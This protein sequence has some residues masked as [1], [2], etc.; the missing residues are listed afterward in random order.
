[1]QRCLVRGNSFQGCSRTA[2]SRATSRKRSLVHPPR[3][4]RGTGALRRVAPTSARCGRTGQ[5]PPGLH[6]GPNRLAV[7]RAPESA[8]HEA[9]RN[10][11]LASLARASAL[12]QPKHRHPSL[13]LL[14]KHSLDAR[15]PLLRRSCTRHATVLR[16]RWLACSRKQQLRT[17]QSRRESIVCLRR[18]ETIRGWHSHA[19][20]TLNRASFAFAACNSKSSP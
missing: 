4:S 6:L 14:E 16:F 1:M 17:G 7:V 9:S 10:T 12:L 2:R 13:L 11:R 18:A 5:C 8:H 19:L 20:P 15:P 3:G